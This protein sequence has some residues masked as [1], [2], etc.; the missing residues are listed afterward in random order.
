MIYNS[1]I[2]CKKLEKRRFVK[3]HFLSKISCCVNESHIIIID[4]NKYFKICAKYLHIF[5]KFDLINIINNL[6]KKG[7]KQ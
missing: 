5:V 2:H 1:K 6:Y 3:Y 4:I 7:G